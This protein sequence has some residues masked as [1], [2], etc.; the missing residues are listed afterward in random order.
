MSP[1]AAMRSQIACT[2]RVWRGSV[3]RTMS[4]ARAFSAS[5]IAANFSATA[6]TNACGETPSLGGGLLNFQAVFVHAGD[7]QHVAPVE[8]HEALDRVGRDPLIGVPDMRRA[9]RVRN[10]GRNVETLGHGA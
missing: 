7:E 5:P 1:L 6:S 9:V 2:A 3:V 10:G 4:S 8:P